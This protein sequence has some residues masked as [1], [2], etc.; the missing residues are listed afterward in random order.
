[1]FILFLKYF[2]LFSDNFKQG[3]CRFL[4]C[5]LARNFS[6]FFHK[7]KISI[8]FRLAKI[9]KQKTKQNINGMSNKV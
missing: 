7:N 4:Y 3:T 6:R 2:I 1:M 5:K 8:L 9:Y